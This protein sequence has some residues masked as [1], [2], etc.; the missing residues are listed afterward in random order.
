MLSIGQRFIGMAADFTADFCGDLVF[1][2]LG[3]IGFFSL[4]ADERG[5]C[6]QSTL[7]NTDHPA[8]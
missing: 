7:I 1:W 2:T 4:W 3:G 8:Q 5:C 6:R